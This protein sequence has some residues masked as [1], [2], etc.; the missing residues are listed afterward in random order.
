VSQVSKLLKYLSSLSTVTSQKPETAE[1]QLLANTSG[2]TNY[3]QKLSNPPIN[4]KPSALKNE[5][6]AA[7]HFKKFVKHSRSLAVT[8]AA[9]NAT[10]ENTKD[11]ISMYQE[12]TLKLINKDRNRK[13]TLNIQEG[14]P[15]TGDDVNRQTEDAKL[16]AAVSA[17]AEKWNGAGQ[18]CNELHDYNTLMRYLISIIVF[19]HYQRPSVACNMTI[20][21]FVRAKTATD[22]CVVVLVS[23]HK[24]S[25]QGP[26]QMAL[27]STHHKL[28]SLYAR[29]SVLLLS[30]LQ[31]CL[32]YIYLFIAITPAKT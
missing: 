7:L 24:T 18:M 4:M 27:E 5:L 17:I 6:N 3:F 16:V 19:S 8:D 25:A 31:C 30:A 10:M 9:F 32:K 29:R 26:A 2:I 20:G 13:T 23:E 12:G 15:F 22:G 28:F 21:E 1:A 14:L 11:I